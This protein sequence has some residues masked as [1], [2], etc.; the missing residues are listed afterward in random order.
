MPQSNDRYNFCFKN[1]QTGGVA[2]KNFKGVINYHQGNSNVLEL[3]R[4]SVKTESSKTILN[5]CIIALEEY[6]NYLLTKEQLTYSF[7]ASLYI[8]TN[9]PEI[10]KQLEEVIRTNVKFPAKENNQD[11]LITVK[12]LLQKEKII[13]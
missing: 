5:E 3:S 8:N 12:E 9:K 7:A 10:K 1:V 6:Y 13:I 2:I 11:I 4:K